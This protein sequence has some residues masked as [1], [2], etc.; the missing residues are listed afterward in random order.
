MPTHEHA[1]R[2][3]ESADGAY[4]YFTSREVNF[5]L[6]KIRLANLKAGIQVETIPRVLHWTLWQVA[7]GG[8]YFVP[9]DAP[10]TMQY[11]DLASRKVK[12]VFKLEK[13]FDDGISVSPDGQY[14]LYAQAD[15]QN[16]EIMLMD[17][18]R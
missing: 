15:E 13:D 18:Y 4:P 14:I 2:P 8:I 16:D 3:A 9:N 10:R 6:Q 7:R 12:D 17:R 11:F 1:L 5:Q